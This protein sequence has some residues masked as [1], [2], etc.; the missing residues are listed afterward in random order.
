[1]VIHGLRLVP[2]YVVSVVH[3]LPPHVFP[4]AAGGIIEGGDALFK[5]FIAVEVETHKSDDRQQRETKTTKR[6]KNTYECNTS[7]H[8][9]MQDT[10][11]K[12]SHLFICIKIGMGSTDWLWTC[13]IAASYPVY[14]PTPVGNT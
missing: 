7:V 2:L 9:N 3:V 12:T 4:N 10:T 1:M 6:K 11:I 8:S 13:T 5:L 14:G